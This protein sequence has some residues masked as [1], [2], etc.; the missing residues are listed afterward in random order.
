[1]ETEIVG[2]WISD[3]NDMVTKNNIGNVTMIFTN[4]GRL[5]YDVQQGKKLQRMFMS[6]RISGDL[7]ISDQP[8][9]SKEQTTKYKL[10]DGDKLILEF[11]G[12]KIIF[13]KA[14]IA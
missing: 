3:T 10:V 14:I 5:I 2:T 8:S 6:Y 11:E 9:Q 1:M 7:I 12:I 4:D 13:K